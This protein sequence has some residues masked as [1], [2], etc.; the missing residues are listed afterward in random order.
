MCVELLDGP[1]NLFSDP[2]SKSALGELYAMRIGLCYRRPPCV[3]LQKSISFIERVFLCPMEVARMTFQGEVAKTKK[4][5]EKNATM[6]VW[7]SLKK[8]IFMHITHM[9]FIAVSLILGLL[10]LCLFIHCV[11]TRYL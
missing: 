11:D 2:C 6:V 1:L 5:D 10:M 4:K 8:R 3:F 9:I 7:S